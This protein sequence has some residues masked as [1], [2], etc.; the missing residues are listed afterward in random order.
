MPSS[1]ARGCISAPVSGAAQFP[2]ASVSSSITVCGE[3]WQ[4]LDLKCVEGPKGP[5]GKIGP[6]TPHGEL[7]YI[8]EEYV[9]E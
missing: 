4:S 8:M 5:Q 3:T 2:A 9:T 7:E 1:A 6:M